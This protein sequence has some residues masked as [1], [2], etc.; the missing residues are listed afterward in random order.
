[1]S[2]N[3][4]LQENQQP[5]VQ[6]TMEQPRPVSHGVTRKAVRLLILSRVLGKN[7]VYRYDVGIQTVDTGAENKIVAD[8]A[9]IMVKCPP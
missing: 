1:M 4:L 5:V 8:A 6:P 7:D 9:E 3:A 2:V